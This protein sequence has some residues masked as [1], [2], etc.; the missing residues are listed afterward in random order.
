MIGHGGITGPG[1][2]E[3]EGADM[4]TSTHD[5]LL[6]L[7][8]R[9]D[10]D[11][12]AWARELVAVGEDTQA[13]ELVTAAVLADRV[14]LPPHVRE[15]LIAGARSTRPDLDIAGALP[16]PGRDEPGHVFDA[17][18]GPVDQIAAVLR[19]LP[20]RR[21]AGCTVHVT[22]RLT[23]AGSAPGPVPHPV[24]L[25]EV[26]P[27]RAT[28][29][30]AYQLATELE[31]AG[32]PASV[33]VF[34]RGTEL[35]AYHQTALRSAVPVDLAQSAP[36]PVSPHPR[37]AGSA[38]GRN[39][40]PTDATDPTL[41][42]TAP[43]A[44][45]I[46]GVVAGPGPGQAP[47]QPGPH[48]VM[49]FRAAAFVDPGHAAQHGIY[50]MAETSGPSHTLSDAPSVAQPGHRSTDTGMDGEHA[51]PTRWVVGEHHGGA[52]QP[53]G[54]RAQHSEERGDPG[55]DPREVS[56]ALVVDPPE[57]SGPAEPQYPAPPQ[58]ATSDPVT[59]ATPQDVPQHDVPTPPTPISAIPAENGSD[60][61]ANGTELGD[62]QAPPRR[63]PS[64]R[65]ASSTSQT[66][67]SPSPLSHRPSPQPTA[68]EPHATAEPVDQAA[69]AESHSTSAEP[70]QQAGSPSDALNGPLRVPLLEPLLDPS[71]REEIPSE[72]GH[73]RPEPGPTTT[74]LQGPEPWVN[75][76]A[77]RMEPHPDPDIPRAAP[78]DQ[79]IWAEPVVVSHD[80]SETE[81]TSGLAGPHGPSAATFAELSNTERELLAMLH[82]ELAAREA[83]ARNNRPPGGTSTN[84]LYPP[85]SGPG[86]G[87]GPA[88]PPELGG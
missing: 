71:P 10:D 69:P 72:S 41:V 9:V 79:D 6:E 52:S 19:E 56:S 3:R 38:E 37:D 74:G 49:L 50:P 63:K 76:P 61:R 58:V 65:P 30:L 26:E 2:I 7:A 24:V 51:S 8:G 18:A 42:D 54:N 23:P 75:G 13:L 32:R 62:E 53:P 1:P 86:E 70:P 4:T 12:L 45:R 15:A 5:L 25:V 57:V 66:V 40:P 20:P 29:V 22:W 84:G 14:A 55:A 60:R 17:A 44:H 16:P 59:V 31:R 78:S 81:P 39:Q 33:E 77:P 82:K 48:Q 88:L 46:D 85:D 68:R 11:L 64:P 87:R 80:G 35:P 47:P 83:N 67:P 73:G 21:L 43:G 28:E 36:T 27:D 34:T